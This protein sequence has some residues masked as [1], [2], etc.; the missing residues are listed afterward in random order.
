MFFF[1][2]RRVQDTS[3]TDV[4]NCF[5]TL[6]RGG[7][8]DACFT[9]MTVKFQKGP[10]HKCLG[11]SIV[12]GTDSPKGTMGIY[13]KTVFPNGQAADVES[14]REGTCAKLLYFSAVFR[15]E[16]RYIIFLLHDWPVLFPNP[17]TQ[18]NLA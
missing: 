11:F 8:K 4:N 18:P 12:G 16:F 7:G 5:Y 9:I 3:K 10:G 13:V 6:P 17:K 1:F 14:L 2:P 15:I